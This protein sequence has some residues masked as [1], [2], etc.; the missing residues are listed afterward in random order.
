[1]PWISKDV[2]VVLPV[3]LTDAMFDRAEQYDVSQGGRYDRRG[4]AIVIW[5]ASFTSD[6]DK[7]E[8]QGEAYF[9]ATS[10]VCPQY[11]VCKLTAPGS[12]WKSMSRRSKRS[13]RIARCAGRPD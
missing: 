6:P 1:M 9:S 2:Q 11:T 4:A 10:S 13:G 12:R 5:S 8:P 3:E 7:A